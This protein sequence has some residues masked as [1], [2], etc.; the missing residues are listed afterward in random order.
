MCADN[1]NPLP[2]EKADVTSQE[3]LESAL[4]L[5]ADTEGQLRKALHLG[6]A[7]SLA[8]VDADQL[9]KV[10]PSLLQSLEVCVYNASK[11]QLVHACTAPPLSADDDNVR[12]QSTVS[13]IQQLQEH[14]KAEPSGAHKP[15]AAGSSVAL[16]QHR[17]P[18]SPLSR[19]QGSSSNR[20]ASARNS[21]F[22]PAATE[23]VL[24]AWHQSKLQ[25]QEKASA[26]REQQLSKERQLLEQLDASQR[27]ACD[28][29]EQVNRAGGVEHLLERETH[30]GCCWTGRQ[31]ED[32]LHLT[33]DR[34][35]H[36]LLHLCRH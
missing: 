12:L 11:R 9:R 16:Y 26:A 5:L 27:Q 20:M 23:H 29:H 2:V 3:A 30:A 32:G 34:V 36:W 35:V 17:G 8:A 13:V 25:Q 21:L 18:V 19:Q 4:Q 15:A 6:P 22:T 14:A 24:A 7:D 33:H 1:S 28:A 31:A 10:P